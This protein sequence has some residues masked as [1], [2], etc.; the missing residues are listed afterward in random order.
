[1]MV[2][3]MYDVK[4]LMMMTMMTIMSIDADNEYVKDD[5]HDDSLKYDD[6]DDD[7]DKYHDDDDHVHDSQSSSY[8]TLDHL[9]DHPQQYYIP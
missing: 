1:M 7:D 9:Y 3:S 2:I 4:K 5:K 6:E 8:I